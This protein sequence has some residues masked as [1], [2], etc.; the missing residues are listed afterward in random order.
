MCNQTIIIE[1]NETKEKDITKV[2]LMITCQTSA[3]I[4]LNIF[5]LPWFLF[6]SKNYVSLR[7]LSFFFVKFYEIWFKKKKKHQQRKHKFI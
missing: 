6:I 1:S 3:I 2:L 5:T 7:F 4:D